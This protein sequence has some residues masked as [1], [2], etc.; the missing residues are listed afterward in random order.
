M[1]SDPVTRAAFLAEASEW[2]AE[3]DKENITP[4]ERAIAL[5]IV[6]AMEKAAAKYKANALWRIGEDN[7]ND[8]TKE[9]ESVGQHRV[10]DE[11][12]VI[13]VFGD[14]TTEKPSATS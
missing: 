1:S 5:V 2:R 7:E 12:N 13:I 9:N 10:T 11:S 3:A 4:T 14:G 6:D 8:I